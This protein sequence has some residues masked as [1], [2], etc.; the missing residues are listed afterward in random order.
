MKSI[1][2]ILSGI[3]C[4]IRLEG[5]PS[6]KYLRSTY[7][8][9]GILADAGR[10]DKR[11]SASRLCGDG[12]FN[13][14]AVASRGWSPLVIYSIYMSSYNIKRYLRKKKIQNFAKCAHTTLSVANIN[15]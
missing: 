1:G 7:I 15:L 3:S 5:N 2:D 8:Y 12:E 11:Q 4:V 10:S 9:F 14:L 13:S 6:Q